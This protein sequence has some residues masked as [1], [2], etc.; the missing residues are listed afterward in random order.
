MNLKHHVKWFDEI[1]GQFEY[2]GKK[3]AHSTEKESTDCL[4]DDFGKNWLFG[5]LAKYCKR[6]SNVAREKDLL[7]I[8]CYCFILWLKRGFHLGIEGTKE[9][10]NTTVEIKSRYFEKFSQRVF[11]FMGD[12]D[13]SELNDKKAIKLIYDRLA[14]FGGIKFNIINEENLFDIFTLCYFVWENYVPDTKKGG[15]Q[16]IYNE[17]GGKKKEEDNGK[18]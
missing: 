7:K 2:G 11:N 15:D 8:A 6:Y 9:S 18:R 5:T 3:Y 14:Y 10:I 16:D 1:R 12:Y 17:T 13:T 4:F